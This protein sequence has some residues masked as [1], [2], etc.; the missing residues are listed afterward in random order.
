M[1]EVAFAKIGM[2]CLKIENLLVVAKQE[3]QLLEVEKKVIERKFE[4]MKKMGGNSFWS[5]P[6]LHPSVEENSNRLGYI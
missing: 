2:E 5:K 1:G 4:A 3:I 6:I